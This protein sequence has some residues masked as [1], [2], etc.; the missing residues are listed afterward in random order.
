MVD[1]LAV[2]AENWQAAQPAPNDRQ[3]GIEN[4][5]SPAILILAVIEGWCER[6]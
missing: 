1:M 3:G 5:Q 6:G 4:G 2:R